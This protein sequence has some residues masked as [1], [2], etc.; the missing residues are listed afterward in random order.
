[1]TPW[2]PDLTSLSETSLAA[3]RLLADVSL[4]GTAVLLAAAALGSL[5]RHH[6]AAARHLV[7]S[8]ALV[9]MLLLP[10]LALLLPA[11]NVSLLPAPEPAAMPA[12]PE[13]SP[14]PSARLIILPPAALPVGAVELRPPDFVALARHWPAAAL[15]LW[16]LGALAVAAR[17]LVGSWGVWRLAR[18][19]EP[20]ADESWAALARRLTGQLRLRRPVRLLR[21]ERVAM[22][23]TWGSWRPV[24]LLPAESAAWSEGWRQIVLLHELAHIKRRDCLTQML[25]QAACAL[26]WFNPLVWTAA[27]RLRAER[28]LACDD[29]VLC[30]GTKASEYA[31][32]L[33]EIASTLGPPTGSPVTV[34]MACSQLEG[35]VRAILDPGVRRR[36]LNRALAALALAL[37]L[38]PVAPLAA[39][40]PWAAAAPSPEVALDPL[41]AAAPEPQ[42]IAAVRDQDPPPAPPA[43]PAPE[44][45]PV[46]GDRRDE[47]DDA[48]E[49]EEEDEE[50][51]AREK[52]GASG[53]S[54]EQIIQMKVAGVTPE[55]V[56]MLR[57]QGY[58]DLPARQ[59]A[60]LSLQGVTEEFIKEA[61]G[62]GGG[63]VTPQ[64]LIN[65]KISGVDGAYLQAMKQ[66][67][68]DNLPVNKLSNLRIHGVTP[69]YVA[70]L[71]RLGYDK[72]TADQLTGLKIHG[73]TEDYIKAT[74]GWLPG[75]PSAQE[76]MQL[77]IHGID[78]AFVKE[79]R[80][81]GFDNLTMEQLLQFRIHGVTPD[82]VK[83]MR[84]AGL[85]NVS[86]NEL[87]R[88]KIHGLDSI[89]LKN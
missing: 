70:A 57:R 18:R 42:P 50:S 63:Q 82:Y 19:A 47:A 48:E 24:V 29:H 8:L 15:A 17:L 2:T 62:W 16:L 32:Y 38:A 35:R 76:L 84:A 14:A 21:S 12:V 7:W 6:A 25:A 3:L 34:G 40:R 75:K 88:L 22:P 30:L 55:Y 74:Q 61:R 80:G 77:R 52:A 54:A 23:M 87:I 68:Y 58:A 45:P 11:W 10:P 49:A 56:E 41:P 81:L 26:Y 9:G 31:R 64:Q 66:A 83:K 27:R 89:L 20:V 39:L 36:G 65:L 60:N 86:A 37:V 51:Q 5:L 13:P 46:A 73:V 72:L 71:R 1:M 53:L 67:G 33:V 69:E 85:K 59:V 79:M 43:P 44:P 78:E 28:E 4:K